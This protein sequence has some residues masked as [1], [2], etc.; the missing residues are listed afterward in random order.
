MTAR[1][2]GLLGGLE[3]LAAHDPAVAEEPRHRAMRLELDSTGLRDPATMVPRHE[4]PPP[5][6]EQLSISGP[7][8]SKA[9]R[10]SCQYGRIP[11]CATIDAPERR[12]R[13]RP[14]ELHLGIDAPEHRVEASA[15]QPSWNRRTS[16]TSS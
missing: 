6:V 13:L 1:L 12:S 7:N 15:I 4:T 8:P 10:T 14:V 2:E 3:Q 11:S 5:A 16:S 9:S